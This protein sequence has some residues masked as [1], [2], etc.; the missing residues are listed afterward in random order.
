MP[1]AGARRQSLVRIRWGLAVKLPIGRGVELKIAPDFWALPVL[2]ALF[3]LVR[4]Q[5]E[6]LGYVPVF[7][8]IVLLSVLVHEVSHAVAGLRFGAPAHKIAI[9][10]FGGLAFFERWPPKKTEAA[11]VLFA[12]PASNAVLAALTYGLLQLISPDQQV[13]ATTLMM[14]A[15]LNVALFVVNLLPAVPLDGGRLAWLGLQL[16]FD[17]K[18]SAKIVGV[19]GILL[20]PIT[21]IFSLA[22]VLSGIPV[23]YFTD[24]RRSIGM[25]RRASFS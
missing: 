24:L 15:T 22:M 17:R 23:A 3:V 21:L 5:P 11:L 7:T 19:L 2:A 9:G 16:F 18:T 13:I 4:E 8:A 6:R 10:F 20:F 25:L 14:A 1:A 12:G